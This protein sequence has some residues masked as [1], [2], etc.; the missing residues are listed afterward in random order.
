MN[1][2]AVPVM[3]ERS[4][5]RQAGHAQPDRAQSTV[6]WGDW[7]PAPWQVPVCDPK[8]GWTGTAD[9]LAQ[10]KADSEAR[11]ATHAYAVWAHRNGWHAYKPP[12]KPWSTERAELADNDHAPIRRWGKKHAGREL[13]GREWNEMPDDTV[14]AGA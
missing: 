2:R 5:R 10:A 6:Q 7:G 13:D 11:G 3:G 9:E 12:H 4:R 1:T 14:V 8:V